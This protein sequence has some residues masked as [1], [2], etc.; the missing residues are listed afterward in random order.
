MGL[1]KST[2]TRNIFEL[3]TQYGDKVRLDR[4]GY[5]DEDGDFIEKRGIPATVTKDW[6]L[7]SEESGALIP[8][9]RLMGGG[10]MAEADYAELQAHRSEV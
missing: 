1:W 7:E 6:I 4:I 9:V 5:L 10:L 8:M 2:Q 3:A